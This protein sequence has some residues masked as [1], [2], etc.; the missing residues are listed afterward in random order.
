MDM[1]GAMADD[2]RPSSQHSHHQRS[3]SVRESGSSPTPGSGR[4]RPAVR[5]QSARIRRPPRHGASPN[6]ADALRTAGSDPRLNNDPHLSP[7]VPTVIGTTPD[8]SPAMRR[9]VST[10]RSVHGSTAHSQRKSNAFLDVP[11]AE[12][13]PLEGEDEE[14]YRLRSFSFTSKGNTHQ[15]IYILSC[16]HI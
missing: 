6:N 9:K 2:G 12:P 3:G 11:H 15:Y 7:Q 5:S 4:R 13:M 8:T 1:K 10:R 16:V 14:S